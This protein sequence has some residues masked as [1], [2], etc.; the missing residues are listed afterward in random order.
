[1]DTPPKN[2]PVAH[3]PAYEEP[4]VHET[5]ARAPKGNKAKVVIGAM[6][7]VAAVVA[8]LAFTGYFV[9][10]TADR[11]IEATAPDPEGR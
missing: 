11:G 1:M 6:L 7:V 10:D 2:K 4:E 8:A 9:S 3:N 5:G